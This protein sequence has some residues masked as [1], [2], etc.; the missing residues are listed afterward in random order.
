VL[1]VDGRLGYEEAPD[2]VGLLLRPDEDSWELWSA[3]MSLREV[4]P[5]IILQLDRRD[6]SLAEQPAWSYDRTPPS[7]GTS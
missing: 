6:R 1:A 2:V 5:E 7:G 3:P 4:E